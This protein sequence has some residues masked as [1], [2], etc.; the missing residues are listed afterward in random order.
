MPADLSLTVKRTLTE[1][2]D[3]LDDPATKPGFEQHAELAEQLWKRLR[4][5]RWGRRP[6]L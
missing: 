2:L 6:V 4:P 3:L 5:E 1:L